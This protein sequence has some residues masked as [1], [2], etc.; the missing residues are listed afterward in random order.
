MIVLLAGYDV[1]YTG[2]TRGSHT[3]DNSTGYSDSCTVIMNVCN[4]VIMFIIIFP[5]GNHLMKR[6]AR[7]VADSNSDDSEDDDDTRWQ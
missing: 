5:E 1:C 4:S 2:V 7:F 3:P 6:S